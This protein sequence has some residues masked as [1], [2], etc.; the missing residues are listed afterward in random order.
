M[1]VNAFFGFLWFIA[2]FFLKN[3]TKLPKFSS[4]LKIPEL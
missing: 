1:F 2:L 4:Y 3:A